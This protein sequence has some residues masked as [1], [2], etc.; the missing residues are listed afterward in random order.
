MSFYQSD[1]VSL[2]CQES[3][4]R[5]R[6]RHWFGQLYFSL[7]HL[8][9]KSLCCTHIC[10]EPNL[11]LLMIIKG[12]KNGSITFYVSLC[13]VH[14][15][16]CTVQQMIGRAGRPGFDLEGHAIIMTQV[17]C[18]IIWWIFGFY[19]KLNLLLNITFVIDPR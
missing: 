9:L 19:K 13:F 10:K 5:V 4:E 7:S 12:H 3:L 17:L 15:Y 16:T 2:Q 11:L 1:Q 14:M 8:L 18:W 6:Y